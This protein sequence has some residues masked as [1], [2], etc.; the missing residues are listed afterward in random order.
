MKNLVVRVLIVGA[1]LCLG[2][3][4]AMAQDSE[5]ADTFGQSRSDPVNLPPHIDAAAD[6][7][8]PNRVTAPARD[9]SSEGS[10]GTGAE[11]QQCIKG[12]ML[13]YSPVPHC[14]LPGH[15]G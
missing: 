4:C 12:S 7:A 10:S 5:V 11:D 8:T 3:Q 15:R 2:S 1:A 9:D 13:C 6:Q 14:C